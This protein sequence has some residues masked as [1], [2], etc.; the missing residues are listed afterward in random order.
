[1]RPYRAPGHL[2]VLHYLLRDLFLFRRQGLSWRSAW[3]SALDYWRFDR[4]I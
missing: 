2:P 4:A 1:M 3:A